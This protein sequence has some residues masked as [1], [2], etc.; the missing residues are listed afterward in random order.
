MD[1]LPCC[2][3]RRRSISCSRSGKLPVSPRT[4]R[5]DRLCQAFL[6]VRIDASITAWPRLRAIIV[7][8]CGPCT[9]ASRAAGLPR[10][11]QVVADGPKVITYRAPYEGWLACLLR[12]LTCRISAVRCVPSGDRVLLTKF[13]GLTFLLPRFTST[14]TCHHV[15][16]GADRT[17][18]QGFKPGTKRAFQ[19]RLLHR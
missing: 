1:T 5:K 19:G 7:C 11:P 3:F 10:L 15:S 14:F 9:A 16:T 2:A 18:I 17:G 12:S 13:A 8:G 6:R 4:R